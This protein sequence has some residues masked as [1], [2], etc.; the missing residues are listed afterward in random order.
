MNRRRWFQSL[1]KAAAIVALAPQLAFRV[2]PELTTL[3]TQFWIQTT[4][5]V[6]YYDEEYRK[7]FVAS[8]FHNEPIHTKEVLEK[9]AIDRF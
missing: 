4:A 3:D 2:K 5:E 9:L 6:S 1:A 8:F 7:A